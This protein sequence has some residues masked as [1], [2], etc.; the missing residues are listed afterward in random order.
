MKY[1]SRMLTSSFRKIFFVIIFIFHG[2]LVRIKKSWKTNYY[3]SILSCL[4]DS[5][6]CH[7]FFFISQTINLKC[8]TTWSSPKSVHRG[9]SKY[10]KSRRYENGQSTE[11]VELMRTQKKSF[12]FSDVQ[13]WFKILRL[14]WKIRKNR[15][16]VKILRLR[17]FQYAISHFYNSGCRV[18]FWHGSGYRP[19]ME[20][21]L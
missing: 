10:R 7:F 9:G 16:K 4:F 5:P 13:N 12:K 20:T 19:V 8:Y 15:E 1:F 21:G 6:W 18:N 2:P 17:N 11:K 3:G 14:L